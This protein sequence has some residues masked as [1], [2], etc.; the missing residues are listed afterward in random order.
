[1]GS[2]LMQRDGV[3]ARYPDRMC[4]HSWS[5]LFRD[6]VAAV[7]SDALGEC[8]YYTCA[9]L[10]DYDMGSLITLLEAE[11]KLDLVYWLCVFAVNQHRSICGANPLGTKDPV[12]GELHP[13]CSCNTRKILNASP[14]LRADGKSVLCELNKF[15]DVMEYC[16]AR[17]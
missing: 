3:Q 14:P 2:L 10:L 12:T 15:D 8:D 7:V 16:A 13:V 11:G 6:L 4:T 17:N 5:S 9:Y 1:M